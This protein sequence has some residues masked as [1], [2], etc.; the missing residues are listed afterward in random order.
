[1]KFSVLMSVYYGDKRDYVKQAIDSIINQT[2]KPNE[3][4]LIIDGNINNDVNKLINQYVIKH[5]KL[6]KIIPLRD[7]V[8]LGEALRIGILECKYDLIARM[9]ADDIARHDR[10]E[11]QLQM[12]F[13]DPELDVVGSYIDEFISHPRNIVSRRKVPLTNSEI[14]KKSKWKCPLNHMTVVY[15]RDAVLK[16]GNY[17][18]FLGFE[19]Y[20]LWFRMIKHGAKF[21]NVPESLVFARVGKEMYHRRGGWKYLKNDIKL[22]KEFLKNNFINIFDFLLNVIIRS[23]F[24]LVPNYF[25]SKFYK[26]FLRT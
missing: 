5:S 2:V 14:Y 11:K 7:N 6:F 19:D 25:R 10:F 1:M 17:Q 15:K 12:F 21:C 4:V 13:N 3:I 22:Q 26:W 20:Y 8:G 23:I 18:T 16:A 9:D 24:R